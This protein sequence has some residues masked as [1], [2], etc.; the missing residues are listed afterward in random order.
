MKITYILGSLIFIIL[1]SNNIYGQVVIGHQPEKA[2]DKKHSL[3]ELKVDNS[4]D[5]AQAFI[6][7]LAKTT[8]RNKI[9]EKNGQTNNG[10]KFPR[11]GMLYDV[12]TGKVSVYVKKDK[13]SP[14]APTSSSGTSNTAD[15]DNQWVY[16]SYMLNN[17]KVPILIARDSNSISSDGSNSSN[18]NSLKTITISAP[19]G[20]VPYTY[21]H[22]TNPDGGYVPYTTTATNS[23]GSNSN[24]PDS[25]IVSL[26]YNGYTLTPY[27]DY[28]AEKSSGNDGKIKV[29]FLSFEPE[30]K[31]DFDKIFV[32]YVLK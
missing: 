2:I 10:N 24:S 16:L 28:K 1:L 22:K 18:N 32:Q 20:Y 4:K 23:G 3:L 30:H 6:L 25:V 13:N 8:Q 11:G 12:S 31:Q 5:T 21:N 17:K 15:K 26:S 14:A 7:P 9:T 27:E 29:T 19:E